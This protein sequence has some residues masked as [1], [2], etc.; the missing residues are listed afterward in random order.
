MNWTVGHVKS[1]AGA[2]PRQ[3]AFR[4][5]E[6]YHLG[7][8]GPSRIDDSNRNGDV[9]AASGTRTIEGSTADAQAPVMNRLAEREP[10]GV[11]AC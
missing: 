8:T 1:G 3:T 11:P 2:A 5:D 10:T 4:R 6:A 9:A 7:Q